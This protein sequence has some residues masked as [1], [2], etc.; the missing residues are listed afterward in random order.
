MITAIFKRCWR[1]IGNEVTTHRVALPAFLCRFEPVSANIGHAWVKCF[2][3][4]FTVYAYSG[5]YN[6]NVLE[7]NGLPQDQFYNLVLSM[8]TRYT[9]MQRMTSINS[10]NRI[11]V[12]LHTRDIYTGEHFPYFIEKC[13]TC[14]VLF[15]F[16]IK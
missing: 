3:T 12:V 9:L 5:I 13:G 16:Y 10:I 6:G 7:G 11:L 15:L 8:P 4:A 14:T 2:S 1:M